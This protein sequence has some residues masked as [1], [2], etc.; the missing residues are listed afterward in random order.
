MS[1]SGGALSGS[2]SLSI[3]SQLLE[4]D[5]LALDGFARYQ[6]A[7]EYHEYPGELSTSWPGANLNSASTTFEQIVNGV[8][9][10]QSAEQGRDAVSALLTSTVLQSQA[11]V[12]PTSTQSWLLSFPTKHLHTELS[13]QLGP[14]SDVW[15]T[16]LSES[17][18]FVEVGSYMSMTGEFEKAGE[19]QLCAAVNLLATSSA[20]EL[21]VSFPEWLTTSPLPGSNISP[22][23]KRAAHISSDSA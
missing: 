10:Q 22:T 13:S 12:S 14:F 17:C 5:A 9:I 16:P 2:A 15:S 6:L 18:D 19:A 20:G 23:A 1:W 11:P 21:P 7:A 8:T 4:Y 3:S